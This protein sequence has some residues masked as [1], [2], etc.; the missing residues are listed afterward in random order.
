[1]IETKIQEK[2]K[3]DLEVDDFQKDGDIYLALNPDYI[4][5][6]NAKYMTMYNRF[7]RWYDLSEKWL[8]GLLYGKAVDKLR[9]ELMAEIEWKDHLS[10]LYVSIGTGHDLCYIPKDVDL[11]SLDF[12]GA[13]ISIGMLKKCQKSC[14]KKTNLQ[15][16]Q[17]CAEDLPFADNS[18]DIVY[19]IGGINF[20]SDKAEGQAVE[21]WTSEA[22]KSKD[23][24]LAPGTYTFHEEAAPTGYLKVTDITFQVKHDGTVEVTNVGEKDSKGEDNKVVTNGSTMT[25]TDKDDDSPKAITFSKVNL[26]GTEIAGAEIK[27]FKG[28]KAEGQAVESW[29]SEA[30]K[31][32]DLNLAPGTYTFHEEA[33]PTGY[34]KVTDITFQVKTDG[35]VEVTNV[36]EKDSKGEDNKVVTNGSTVTVTDKDDD[37]P[38]AITF[39]KVNLGGTEIAGAQIKIYKGDK[40]EGNP[41]ESWTSEAGKSKELNLAPGTYTFHEEAAP[42]GYLKVTDITFQVKH[43]GTVEVTN[44]GEKDSKGE[45][46]KVVTN[47]SKV[48][49][50]D[51]DD[52]LPRKVTFSKINQYGTEIGSAQIQIFRG[53]E[54][55]GNPVAEWTSEVNKSHDLELAPGV[56]TFHEATAPA[57]YLAVKDITFQVNFDGTIT[58]LNA[59]GNTVEYKDGK[60]VVTDQSIPTIPSVPNKPNKPNKPDKPGNKDPK[61][62]GNGKPKD[63]DKKNPKD[64]GKTNPKDS[65][66]PQEKDKT[67]NTLPLTGTELSFTLLALGLTMIVGWGVYYGTRFKN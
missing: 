60:L 30:G 61:D 23:L 10:V 14:S 25:V 59:N 38:K 41:V 31:S 33:A 32:K 46:N 54:A 27:I 58:I 55:T 11:K 64:P 12:F 36:G 20:F 62:P 57:G 7:A 35:T 63:P 3:S 39:S 37:S 28:D 17:A 24:N 9:R 40:A 26:G 66:K 4:S 15:L 5:G 6:D 29:T 34:L 42:T 50:T 48:T 13:D 67:K 44:V 52:D 47:G 19:H 8:G 45:D 18:F 49:V 43:D 56:Y 2:L 53:N 65:E 21:S 16:F 1:M 22:G 51:K